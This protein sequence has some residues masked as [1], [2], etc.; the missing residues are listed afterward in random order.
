[1]RQTIDVHI[2]AREA[3]DLG[4]DELAVGDKL[5]VGIYSAE[6]TLVDVIRLR[7][8][9]GSN[10]AWEALRRWLARKGSRPPALLAMA[11]HFHGAERAVRDAMEIVL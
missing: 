5:S 7:H 3:F 6:R 1:L 4:R 2:F 8:R 9:E 11:K 10:V